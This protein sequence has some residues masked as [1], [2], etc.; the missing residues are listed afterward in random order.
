MTVRSILPDR[1]LL[2]LVVVG[3]V[4]GGLSVEAYT[5][6]GMSRAQR[7]LPGALARAFVPEGLGEAG[8]AS[9]ATARRA[10][11]AGEPAA[12]ARALGTLTEQRP[13][14]ELHHAAALAWLAAG[15]ADAAA[16]QAQLAARLA[17][18]DGALAADAERM[19]NQD[20]AWHAR[21]WTRPAAALAAAVLLLLL[22][23][24]WHRR[25]EQRRL[26]DY[27]AGLRARV[28]AW[29]DGE[30][31]AHPLVLQPGTG[32]L[33]LDV[34][35]RGRH[36]LACPRRPEQVPALHLVLSSAGSNRT[37]RLRP[38]TNV[39]GDAV[40]VP[41]TDDTLGR[42][43]A[44]PGRWRLHLRLGDRPLLAVPLEVR[45][46][47]AARLRPARMRAHG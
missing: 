42:L 7:A 25:R 23:G 30:P 31:L 14:P 16:R 27:L 37:L 24:A 21:P 41:V 36:G 34:F 28:D 4:A 39:C 26:H 12:A 1:A 46:A 6:T 17:P 33:T 18:Q 38:V 15:Q 9:L 3:F 10:A 45:A 22:A 43:L 35:L 11:R 40:R 8:A 29:A 5:R 47:P 19:L 44:R 13:T 32:S 20:M 2:G